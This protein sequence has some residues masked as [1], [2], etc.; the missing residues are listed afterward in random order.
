MT[1][2]LENLYI[3]RDH[4]VFRGLSLDDHKNYILFYYDTLTGYLLIC[5]QKEKESE[6][7]RKFQATCQEEFHFSAGG[8]SKNI[9]IH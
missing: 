9:I 3:C 8:R 7:G 1:Q 5:S 6:F 4:R 2:E